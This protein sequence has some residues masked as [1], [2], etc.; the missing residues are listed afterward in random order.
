MANAPYYMRGHHLTSPTNAHDV[1][2]YA[3]LYADHQASDTPIASLEEHHN[4]VELLE[5]ATTAAGQA[6]QAM[7]TGAGKRK[8]VESSPVDDGETGQGGGGRASGNKRARRGRVTTDPRLEEA[9]GGGRERCVFLSSVL[10]C[11]ALLTLC[12][13]QIRQWQC[14]PRE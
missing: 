10:L 5:A 8:R 7:Q 6:N 2:Q 3:A 13:L 11:I 4:F 14:A 9:D 12:Q 1:D